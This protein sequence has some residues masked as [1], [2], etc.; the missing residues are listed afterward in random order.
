MSWIDKY[1]LFLFD[2]D[3]LLVNTEEVHFNAYKEMCRGRGFTLPWDFPK[4]FRIA[5][6]DAQ[7]LERCIYAEFPQLQKSEPTWAILY[8]EKSRAFLHLL[9]QTPALLLS[10]AEILLRALERAN[11][12]R[13]VVTHSSK[14]LASLLMKQ[15]PVLQTIEHWFTRQ[16]Y[17]LPKPAPDGYLKAIETLAEPDDAI[18]GF[19][20]SNRGLVSLMATRAYPV[21]VNSF[22]TEMKTSFQKQGVR[23]FNTLEEVCLQGI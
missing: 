19:E 20:D 13:C 16:D 9:E 15:N 21:L 18:V 23:V 4:Y 2:L 1:Q 22:D 11:K 5:N 17:H 6:A 10:G 7:A 14:E 12:K 8:K 3:G